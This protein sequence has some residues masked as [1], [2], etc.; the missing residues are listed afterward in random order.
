MYPLKFIRRDNQP[1]VTAAAEYQMLAI[2]LTSD[3]QDEVTAGEMQQEI[4]AALEASTS[5]TFTSNG[6]SIEMDEKGMV[7]LSSLFSDAQDEHLSG[8]MLLSA[9]QHW[10]FFLGAAKLLVFSPKF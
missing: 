1:E 8:A 10:E 5:C 6:H 2:F 3:V 9:L 4:A 7:C